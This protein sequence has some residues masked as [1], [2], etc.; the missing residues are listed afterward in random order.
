MEE[1]KPYV[2]GTLVWYY[3]IC[4]R[5]VWLMTHQV[6]PDEDDSNMDLGRFIHETSYPRQNKKEIVIGHVKLDVMRFDETGRPVIGEIKKS[7]H[8]LKS[9]HMQLAYYLLELK[10]RGIDAVGEILIPKEKMTESV[11]LNQ[12]LEQQLIST[13]QAI[14][15]LA[16][17]VVPPEPKRIGLC[18]TCAYQEL[19]WS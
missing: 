16:E 12:A 19:C 4:Q 17:S 18:R 15:T 8:Y 7:S 14:Q 10:R 5:E 13:E 11:E 2:T 9:S 1:E 3:F 6:N